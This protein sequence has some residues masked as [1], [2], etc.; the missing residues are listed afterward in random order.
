MRISL[1]LPAVLA[2]LA[3]IAPGASARPLGTLPPPAQ[4]LRSPDARDAAAAGHAQTLQDLAHLRAQNPR[5]AADPAARALAQQEYYTSYGHPA[6]IQPA[7]EADDSSPWLTI[8]LGL[9]LIV[10]VAGSVGF[11]VRTRR[12]STRVRVAV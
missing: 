6:A 5:T 10:L 2:A 8:G 11:A 7:A 4:D 12:R 9:G 3:L 1:L